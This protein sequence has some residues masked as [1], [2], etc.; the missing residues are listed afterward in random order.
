[1]RIDQLGPDTE[2]YRQGREELE[3][4]LSQPTVREMRPCPSCTVPCPCSKSP[5]CTCA[6]SPRCEHA[7]RQM[8]SEPD[9]YP[10]EAR[11]VPLVY[12]LYALKVCDPCWSCEGHCSADGLIGKIPQV[13][14]YSRSLLYPRLVSEHLADLLFGKSLSCPWHISITYSSNRGV[15]TAFS[16]EP[17]LQ[18]VDPPRLEHL[19][20]DVQR[21]ADDLIESVRLRARRTVELI[22]SALGN[23]LRT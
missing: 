18:L 16:I 10:I 7:P 14:F 8:S 15:D 5:T 4:L 17:R 6:C 2:F 3:L 19:Q 22:D 11:V 20:E 23:R 1:M 9:R 12:E 21:I 13:W